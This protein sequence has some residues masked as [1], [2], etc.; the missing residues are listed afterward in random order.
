MPGPSQESHQSCI[1][2]LGVSTKPGKPPIVYMCVRGFNFVSFTI[3]RLDV[4]TVQLQLEDARI[5]TGLPIFTKTE[6]LY[7]ETGWELLAVRRKRRKLQFFYNIVNKNT[8]N[9]LCTLIPP[10]YAK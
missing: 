3:F 6:I 1:C 9:Y 5:V 7:I 4:G 8:P 10:H 2:V